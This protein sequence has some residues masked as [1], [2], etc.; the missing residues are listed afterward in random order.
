VKPRRGL[1]PLTDAAALA[2]AARRTALV[3]GALVAAIVAV[4]AYIC[5]IAADGSAVA[6]PGGRIGTVV[7]LDVSGSIGQGSAKAIRRALAAEIR[8]VGPHG[9]VGLVLFSDTAFEALP[10]TAPSPALAVYRRLY[11]PHI[12]SRLAPASRVDGAVAGMV[13]PPRPWQSSFSGGTSIS[14][15]LHAAREALK[16][17]GDADGRVLLLSDLLDSPSDLPALHRELA[18][19]AH[20]ARLDLQVRALPGYQHRQ[21][22]L[23]RA[24]LGDRA[25]RPSHVAPPAWPRPVHGQPLPL[26]LLIGAAIAAAALAAWELLGVPMR[27]R[28]GTAAA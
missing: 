15:G 22:A 25:V 14:T 7:V 16:R 12:R 10:P 5:A 4:A 21:L 26:G 17:A 13:Y 11:V 1:L 23:Y 24:V 19:F 3:R 27:W 18:A 20:H 28:A 2:G 6:A 8:A 9:R